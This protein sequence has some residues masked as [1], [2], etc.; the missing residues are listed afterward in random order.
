MLTRL[1]I[2]AVLL[3]LSA[4]ATVDGVGQDVQ[5]AGQAVSDAANDVEDGL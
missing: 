4:C 1:S 2:L 5:T 3:T